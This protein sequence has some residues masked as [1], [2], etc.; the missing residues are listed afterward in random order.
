MV[1]GGLI[2]EK[3][4][5]SNKK[6]NSRFVKRLFAVIRIILHEITVR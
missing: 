2:K 3:S 1:G 6:T 4:I 5:P